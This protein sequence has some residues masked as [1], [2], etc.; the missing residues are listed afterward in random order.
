MDTLSTTSQPK[1]ALVLG[2]S[3]GIGA[4]TATEL[5]SKGYAVVGTHRGSGVP[6]GVTPLELDLAE[7][8]NIPVAVNDAVKLLGGLDTLIVA[9]GITR[10]A[11]LMRMDHSA[12]EEVMQVNAIGPMLAAKAALRPMLRQ[13]AGSI[14]IV[15]STSARIG[16]AGQT[17]YAA[18]KGAVEAFVRSLAR[19]HGRQGLRVNAVAPGA[20]DTDMVAAMPDAERDAMIASTPLGRLARPEEIAQVVVNTAEASY[21]SG[22]VVSVAGGL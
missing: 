11:L 19:E 14:V 7:L 16:V 5:V 21:M 10:D 15:S 18:S 17:N 2:A 6:Q 13:R 22:A 20:T 1:R 9:A 4:A 12:I 3:R 8:E